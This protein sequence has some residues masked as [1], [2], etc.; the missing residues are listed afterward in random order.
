MVARIRGLIR[1][2]ACVAAV[3]ACP[4]EVG[5]REPD[6]D[7]PAMTSA[8][9]CRDPFLQPFAVDSI[10]NTAIGS[11]AIYAPAN[12]YNE[13]VGHDRG[14]PTNF[15]N[16]QDWIVRASASDP[17]TS[18]INDAGQ[19]PGLCSAHASAGRGRAPPIR[20]PASLVTDCTPNNNAAAVLMPDNKTILQFQ[21]LYRPNASG[22]II[23]WYHAGAPQD[24]PWEISITSGDKP[25]LQSALG[26]H[27]GSG[28]SGIGGTIRLGELLPG[29][30]ISHALKL[31]LWTTPYVFGG[32]PSLQVGKCAPWSP[33]YND[34]SSGGCVPSMGRN[35][36]VWPAIG[37]DS[38]SQTPGAKGGLY[39]G[40]DRNFAPGSLLAIP[41]AVADGVKTTTAVGA[42]IKQALIDYGGYFVDGKHATVRE[43][44]SIPACL[45]MP[46]IPATFTSYDYGCYGHPPRRYR[47]EAGRCSNLHGARRVRRGR[48]DV[49]ARAELPHPEPGQATVTFV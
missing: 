17:L 12:I 28:L 16:D 38:G 31:E 39:K 34:S 14:P 22:P 3:V 6:V 7:F 13:S 27:G 26:S 30:S 24:F 36:Y 1:A 48:E 4:H 20:F 42:K 10:W 11:A 33:G 43:R 23:G 37:S 29:G 21:P 46:E 15:H 45:R 18:W 49:R 25:V 2:A 41:P 40:S 47:L 5:A 8:D 9:A 32:V 35:Q 44:I 19:F